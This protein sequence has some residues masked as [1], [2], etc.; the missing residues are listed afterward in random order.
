MLLPSPEQ[1]CDAPYPPK[2][3]LRLD[4]NINTNNFNAY[5]LHTATK[6]SSLYFMMQYVFERFEFEE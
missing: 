5:E 6:S 2:E 4:L 1:S 3:I